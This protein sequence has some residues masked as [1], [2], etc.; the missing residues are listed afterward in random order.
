MRES[1]KTF[2]FELHGNAVCTLVPGDR[3]LWKTFVLD[4]SDEQLHHLIADLFGA[5]LDTTLTTL[6][7]A[8]LYLATYPDTQDMVRQ[9]IQSLDHFFN[10]EDKIPQ[11]TSVLLEIQRMCPVVP[12][13]VPHGTLQEVET[14]GKWVIP[15]GSMLMVNHW[16]LNYNPKNYENPETFK[17]LRFLENDIINKPMPFQVS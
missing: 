15:Q 10:A 13:G 3:K 5:G 11:T 12:L 16:S 17:P 9:E 14:L 4:F 6:K 1:G 7:W 2:G 8:L